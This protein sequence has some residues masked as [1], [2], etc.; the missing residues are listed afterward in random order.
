MG[1]THLRIPRRSW[2]PELELFAG[3]RARQRREVAAV[4]TPLD[5]NAGRVLC[6]QGDDAGECFIV[7]A[8]R[9]DV[10]IDQSLVATVGPG[11]LV[12][13]LALLA[14]RGRRSATVVAATDMSLLA[15]SRREFASLGVAAPS[16]MQHVLGNATRRL[17]ENAQRSPVALSAPR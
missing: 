1:S 5:V 9:A 12:G 11:D 17:T 14:T 16:A 13:E 8:G 6:R 10:F 7:V 15:L 3:C 4:C 2:L